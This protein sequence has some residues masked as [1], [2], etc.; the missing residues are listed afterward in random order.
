MTNPH[1]TY[2]FLANPQEESRNPGRTQS[3]NP[4]SSSYLDSQYPDSLGSD[5][6]SIALIGPD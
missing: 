1:S 5:L 3:V 6:L 4:S 2:Q